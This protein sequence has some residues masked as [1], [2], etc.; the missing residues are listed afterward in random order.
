MKEQN[1]KLYS[2]DNFQLDVGNRQLRRGDIPLVLPPR[3][4]D[5]L[6]VLV[7]NNGRLVKKDE[8]FT[9]V[10]RDLVVEESNL[11][12][13]ISQIRKVLG[14]S[15]DKPRYI[16]TVPGFGYRFIGEIIGVDES[17]EIVVRQE[18]ATPL[19]VK[20]E[21]EFS[22]DVNM[23][24]VIANQLPNV[25]PNGAATSIPPMLT[26]SDPKSRRASRYA[27]LAAG[28]LLFTLLAITVY[29]KFVQPPPAR[30][31]TVA[32]LPFK[33]LVSENRNESLEM[34]MA[35]TL[36]TKLSNFREIQIRP[37]SAVRKYAGI[38][39]DAVA[40]GREQKVDAVLDGQI[41]KSDEKIR[42]TVRLVRVEDGATIWTNQF[43]EQMT[44][45]FTVQDSISERVAGVLVLKLSGEEKRQITKRDT[46][47]AEAYQFYLLGRYHLNRL[48]DDGFVKGRDY[49]QQA[50]DKDPNYAPAY[51]GLADAYNRLSGF[52]AISPKEGFPK[53]EA[54]SLKALEIDENLAEAHNSLGTVKF[55]Y[56]R[57]WSAAETEFRRAIEINPAYS[58]ARQI[59]SYFL[60]AMGRFDEALAE[61][62]RA[63]ELDPLSLEK[64]AGIGE[65]LYLQRR[66][67]QAIEQ[68]RKTLEMDPNSGFAHW[69]IGNAYVQKAMYNEAVAEYQKAIA[70]SGD[71]PDEPAMLGFAYALSGKS[72]EARQV[73]DEL[74]KRSQQSYISPTTIAVIYGGLGENDAAFEWLEK[75]YRE[76]DS[77]LVLLKVE[78]M[79]D[80]IRNDPK[81]TELLRRVNLPQ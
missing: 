10:W 1:R 57:D 68:F 80:G 25:T 47:N 12:V 5:L 43:D 54:A 49:F 78:P 60:S 48:T 42:V 65:V 76:Q 73:I 63:Q 32:V 27:I 72:R 39:Q 30:I 67:D 77:L 17:D 3:A 16:E 46:E 21:A 19:L 36:I 18:T 9:S 24:P 74:K 62:K 64:L 66:Y 52:N 20:R 81:F 58:D 31:K 26:P 29:Y 40:A 23:P 4:F 56:E 45:I 59:Y 2:F 41:Q 28:G 50:I 34:G 69:A 55:F 35:D 37:M 51:A 61:M 70:L 8:L 38:E 33:P 75:A 22:D 79:F 11:T 53:A 6:L 15:K 14:E 44:D 13:H 7:E 71:S